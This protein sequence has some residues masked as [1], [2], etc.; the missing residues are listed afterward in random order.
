MGGNVFFVKGNCR[1][2]IVTDEKIYFYKIDGE[3]FLPEL[4]NV[5]NNFMDCSSMMF[6][7]DSSF[8]ITYKTNERSFEIFRRKFV[9]DYKVNVVDI[10]L[11]GSRGLPIES[12]NAFLVS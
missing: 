2:Q 1:I 6:G 8:C 12:M 5:M 7:M 9:H 3:T 11:E 4:E 10:N